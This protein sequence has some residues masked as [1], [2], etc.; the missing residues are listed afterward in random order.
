MLT[1]QQRNQAGESEKP[2]D[3]SPAEQRV[4]RAVRV[5]GV[6]QGV[7]FRPFVYRLALQN[8]LAGH[9]GN[10]TD[11]VTIEVEGTEAAVED[12]LVR[13]RTEAPPISRIDS[14]A[15]DEVEPIG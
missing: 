13:L 8:R 14:V 15:V 6:V 5:T 3:L 10:D 2:V 9:I 1:K 4:R 11:G 12:F 7:G